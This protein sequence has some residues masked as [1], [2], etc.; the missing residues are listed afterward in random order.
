MGTLTGVNPIVDELGLPADGPIHY[1][2]LVQFRGGIAKVT[3][4]ALAAYHAAE[5]L[6]RMKPWREAV[7]GLVTS[8]KPGKESPEAVAAL[9]DANERHLERAM[10]AFTAAAAL[11]GW[12]GPR[13][14]GAL[15]AGDVADEVCWEWLYEWLGEPDDGVFRALMDRVGLVGQPRVPDGQLSIDFTGR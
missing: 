1:S 15:D 7:H 6:A 11:K 2:E 3:T 12:D 10:L 13:I 4:E 8:G 14:G 9:R 5:C